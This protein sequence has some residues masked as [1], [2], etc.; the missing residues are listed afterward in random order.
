L[1]NPYLSAA[2]AAFQD[3]ITLSVLKTIGGNMILAGEE[4]HLRGQMGKVC[5]QDEEKS[6]ASW[7]G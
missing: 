1:L 5:W 2:T 4:P 7:R 3:L 6:Q